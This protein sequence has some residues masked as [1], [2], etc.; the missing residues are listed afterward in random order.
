MHITKINN[1]PHH[2]GFKLKKSHDIITLNR[3]KFWVNV[4]HLHS[5][6]LFL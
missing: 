4:I 3:T 5:N 2:Q 6:L 1:Q